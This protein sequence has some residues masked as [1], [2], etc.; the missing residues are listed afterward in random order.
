M[1]D[2]LIK[3]VA[4]AGVLMAAASMMK[5]VHVR[6]W[7]AA[8]GGAAVFGV[9]NVLLG[10][11]LGFLIKVFALPIT[12]ITL[13][14]FLLVVPVLVNM[15]LLKIADNA[16]GD[17]VQIESTGGLFGLATVVSVTGFALEKLL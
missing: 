14:L 5:S 10:W 16:S 3:W 8:F 11:L 15:V 13:G 1:F 9:A 2:L 17:D 6:S 4:Y 12:I 7:G